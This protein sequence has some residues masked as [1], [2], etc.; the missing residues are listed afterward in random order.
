MINKFELHSK[1]GLFLLAIFII[2]SIGILFV[3]Y[4]TLQIKQDKLELYKTDIEIK[5]ETYLANLLAQYH[6]DL[7]SC[8]DAINQQPGLTEEKCIE[9]VNNSNLAKIIR[10]WGYQDFLVKKEDIIPQEK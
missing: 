8:F 10:K 9:E 6:G 2:T 7:Q 4:R 1:I 5:K 3:G